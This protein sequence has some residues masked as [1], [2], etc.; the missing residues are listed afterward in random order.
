MK[1]WRLAVIDG[2]GYGIPGGLC[3]FHTRWWAAPAL[4]LRNLARD[5]KQTKPHAA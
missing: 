4:C 3:L 1:S 5:L 2:M